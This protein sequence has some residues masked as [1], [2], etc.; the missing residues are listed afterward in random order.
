[1]LPKWLR[2]SLIF[3]SVAFVGYVIDA[4]IVNLTGFIAGGLAVYIVRKL[5]GGRCK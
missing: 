3:A 4:Y 5:E 1:M 2:Y